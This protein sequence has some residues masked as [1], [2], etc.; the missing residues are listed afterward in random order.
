MTS[1]QKI[2]AATLLVGLV[3][4]A[5]EVLYIHHE[6][7]AAWTPATPAGESAAES[8]SAIDPDD[9]VFL[10]KQR[11]SSLADVKQLTGA[12]LWVSAGGQ[13]EYYPYNSHH[14]DFSKPAGTLLG[15]E[16]LIIQDA[17]EQVAPKQTQYRIP[18]G[19]KQVFLAFTM[20]RSPAPAQQYAVPVGYK[21]AGDYTFSTDE[22][23]FYDDP[24]Q[25]YNFWDSAIWSDIDQHKVVPGMSENQVMMSIGQVMKPSS[26][27]TGD[28]TVFYDNDGH[29]VT[30]TFVHNK[31]VT[32]KPSK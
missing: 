26:D 1:A 2:A 27:N 6:R 29:P 19:D 12:T 22:I 5:G 9:L 18:A 20:P 31:A 24:H 7:T 30:I 32:I 21:E 3:A 4:I 15:A 28:R 14:I 10:K 8:A 11:P 16:P 17:F 23:F 13:M 25:L